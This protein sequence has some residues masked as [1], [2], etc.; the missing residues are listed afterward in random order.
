MGQPVCFKKMTSVQGKGYLSQ[1]N[2][3]SEIPISL[4]SHKSD[5]K[6]YKN[7]LKSNKPL[8]KSFKALFSKASA[9]IT[10]YTKKNLEQII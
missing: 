2:Q 1:K 5:N 9:D 7:S 4:L 6:D 8:A 3:V 10:R